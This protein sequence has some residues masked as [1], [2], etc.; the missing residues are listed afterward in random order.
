M[1]HTFKTSSTQEAAVGEFSA[2]K[3]QDGQSYTEKHGP[4]KPNTKKR[5]GRERERL[6]LF[7]E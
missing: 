1:A 7:K 3:L 6:T 4:E 5:K 2:N